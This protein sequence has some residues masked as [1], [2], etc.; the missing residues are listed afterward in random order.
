MSA[1]VDIRGQ[2]FGELTAIEPTDRR[3]GNC[4]IWRCRCSCGSEVFTTAKSLRAGNAKSCGHLTRANISGQR[5]GRLTAIEPTDKTT[6]SGVIWRCRCDCGNEAFVSASSLRKGNTKSCGC[7]N[8]ERRP[9]PADRVDGTRIALLKSKKSK[10]NTSGIRGVSWSKQKQ[11]WEA[12]IC[13]KGVKYHLGHF[14]Q[15]EDAAKARARAEESLFEPAISNWESQNP[16]MPPVPKEKHVSPMCNI[17]AEHGRYRVRIRI[18]GKMHNLGAYDSLSTAIS[19]R[20][21]KRTEFGL[22]PIPKE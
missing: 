19:V 21:K 1:P 8:L 18:N 16:K 4:I 17:S 22:P 3:S 14:K 13:F 15:L 2:T 20:D 5:F 6:S 9:D 12:S 11:D 7:L 10:A